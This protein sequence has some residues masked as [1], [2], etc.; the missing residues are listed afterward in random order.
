MSDAP[1]AAE[2]EEIA[3]GA[4]PDG[5]GVVLCEC[6]ARDGL[7]HEPAILPAETKIA[8]IERI[9][10]CG[11]R[12]IEIT[13][14]AHPEQV[15]QFADA[16]AVLKGVRRRPGVLFKA[17]CPNPQAVKRA[18]AAQEGGW[19]PDEISL[20]ISASEGHSQ[21]NLRR[22][23]EEQ[24]ANV[25]EMARLAGDAFV[26]VGTISVAFDCPFDGRTPQERVLEDA[27]RF[28]GLGV[29]RIAIGDTIGSATPP[30]VRDLIGWLHGALPTATFIAHFHDSR[31]TG[32][33]NT[34]AAIEAGLTHADCALGGTGGHPAKIAYGEGHTGNTCT[35][36]LATALEAMGYAIG[37]DLG[38]VRGA[39]LEAERVLGR[40]LASRVIRA[41][42]QK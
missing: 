1:T 39:G 35:E 14:F 4:A 17:T 38:L 32:I 15:P 9:A 6:F 28:A 11:F 18:L 22:S 23:R 7:Q 10:D 3:A 37:L 29:T 26:M 24:W 2:M 41:D 8:M 12:R 33:A 20:L 5:P 30:R 16:E 13:S 25:A 42:S 27:E 21:R 31:G 19:G 36:D 40:Q 34:L